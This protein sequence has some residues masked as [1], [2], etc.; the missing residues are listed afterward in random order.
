MEVI[1]ILK[2]RNLKPTNKLWLK[3]WKKARDFANN[4]EASWAES[5]V[6]N[7]STGI[8]QL[9]KHKLREKTVS[10]ANKKRKKSKA[11][12]PLCLDLKLSASKTQRSELYM[13]LFSCIFMSD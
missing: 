3:V 5:S 4:S 8:K 7:K 13:T 12:T 2:L 11:Q 9:T 1:F 6:L 10:K